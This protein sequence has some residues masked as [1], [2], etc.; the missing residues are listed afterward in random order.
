[1][2]ISTNRHIMQGM[3]ECHGVEWSAAKQTLTGEVDVVGG[4]DFVL[5]VACNGWAF[6]KGDG[7]EFRQNAKDLLEV[8]IRS[9]E[10]TRRA[11]NVQFAAG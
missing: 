9:G 3:M 8:V 4:E 7:G 2:I 1:Q 10:S 6:N 11:F 5:T